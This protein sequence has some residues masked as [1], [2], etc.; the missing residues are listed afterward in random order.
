[1]KTR[2]IWDSFFKIVCGTLAV[3]LLTAL[4]IKLFSIDKFPNINLEQLFIG[5]VVALFLP[6]ISKLDAFGVKLEIKEHIEKLSGRLEALPDYVLG[7]EFETEGDYILA[8]A[9]Y[10]ASLEKCKEFWPSLLGLASIH[11][12]QENYVM[13]YAEYK[14]VLKIDPKNVYALNN[15]AYLHVVAPFPLRN[16]DKTIEM[17]DKALE[18][19]PN[20]GS[21]LYYKAV[22]HNMKKNYPKALEILI[23]IINNE[24]L[25]NSLHEV[26]YETAIANSNLKGPDLMET[27]EKTLHFAVKCGE[28]S[29]I[30]HRLSDPEEQQRFL[31]D[32]LQIIDKFLDKHKKYIENELL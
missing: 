4:T 6:F 17:A 15:L 11:D 29:I 26:L 23:Q 5:F 28:E 2:I 1:M 19:V 25:P 12:E 21:S 9:S 14:E 18:Q 31:K 20:L 7:S 24:L 8:E 27:L 10:R 3:I 13:A 32:D 16:F 22:A 30:L